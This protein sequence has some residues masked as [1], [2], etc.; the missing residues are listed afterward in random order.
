MN[1]D[2]KLELRNYLLNAALNCSYQENTLRDR[3]CMGVA[4]LG[5]QIYKGLWPNIISDI[6]N[7][8]NL[9]EHV[10]IEN[11]TL[12]ILDLLAFIPEEL[13]NISTLSIQK[14]YT[15]PWNIGEFKLIFK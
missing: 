13:D 15:Y 3:L 5:V 8:K 11:S 2:E 7:F 14:R 12:L 4:A 9:Y 10:E 6:L 1:Q